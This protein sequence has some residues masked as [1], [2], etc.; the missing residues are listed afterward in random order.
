M[1]VNINMAMQSLNV[2]EGLKV[3]ACADL[4]LCLFQED[5]LQMCNSRKWPLDASSS[6]KYNIK[7]LSRRW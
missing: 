5:A 7:C 2:S 6:F 1:K 3:C 4:K